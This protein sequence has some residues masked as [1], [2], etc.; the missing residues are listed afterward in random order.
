MTAIA[1]QT[2]TL[3][4]GGWLP[5]AP[6][7]RDH[8][9]APASD[10]LAAAKKIL[11]EHTTIDLRESGFMP[12]VKD[13]GQLGSCTAN[14]AATNNEYNLAREG[15]QGVKPTS[16][17]F[18]YYNERAAMGTTGSDSGATIRGSIKACAHFGVP[19]ESEWPYHIKNFKEEPPT[20]DFTDALAD[21]ALSYARVHRTEPDIVA[22]LLNKLAVQMGFTVF[23]SFES[24]IGS[25]GIMPWPGK[26]EQ[27]IGGHA[28]LVVGITWI[29]G[30]A[31]WIV[32]NSWGASW[33]DAGDYYMPIK[34]LITPGYA[35]DYWQVQVVGKAAGK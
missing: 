16:R 21:V 27:S 32:R 31:Y 25:D 13:Q 26:T 9:A 28:N 35:S 20:E 19:L 12:A 33:G 17:L 3:T 24:D 10:E 4:R 6:D 15:V 11:H 5:D 23:P 2:R 18:I 29:N 34:Y 30:D 1:T 14:S 8:L 22:S 7:Y